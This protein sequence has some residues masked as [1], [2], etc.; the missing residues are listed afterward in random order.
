[1]IESRNGE[2]GSWDLRGENG[3]R[4]G[5]RGGRG[6]VA[7]AIECRRDHGGDDGEKYNNN[8]CRSR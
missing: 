6:V 2:V 7:V 1:M 8:D 3:G 5:G 4:D